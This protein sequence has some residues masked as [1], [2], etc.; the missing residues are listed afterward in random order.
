MPYDT[1]PIALHVA[2]PRTV[3]TSPGD[4]ASRFYIYLARVLCTYIFLILRRGAPHV[5]RS[6]ELLIEDSEFIKSWNLGGLEPW[7][8]SPY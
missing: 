5:D 2:F 6:L 7:K 4:D 3:S 1:L 8:G